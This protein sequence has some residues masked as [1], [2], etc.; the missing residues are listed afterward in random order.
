MANLENNAIAMAKHLLRRGYVETL[1]ET[2][3]RVKQ[4]TSSDIQ[5]VMGEVFA[6]D[7]RMMVCIE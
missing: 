1:D 5:R 4:V 3:E 7:R 6:P 2:C